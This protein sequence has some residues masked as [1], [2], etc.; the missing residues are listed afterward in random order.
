MDIAVLG[1]DLGKTIC[2]LAGQDRLVRLCSVN[3]SNDIDFLFSRALASLYR[4]HGRLRWG[5]SYRTV[6]C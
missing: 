1:I 2:S 5:A 4:C 3:V 6:L